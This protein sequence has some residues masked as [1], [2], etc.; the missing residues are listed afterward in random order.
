MFNSN[1]KLTQTPA[2]EP[3]NTIKLE[4]S[5]FDANVQHLHVSKPK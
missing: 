5:L 2:I 4:V 3:S 1:L